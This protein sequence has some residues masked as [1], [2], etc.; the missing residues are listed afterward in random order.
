MFNTLKLIFSF[1]GL[2]KGIKAIP[3]PQGPTAT[4]VAAITLV[5][6]NWFAGN[7]D[8]FGKQ[9]APWAAIVVTALQGV[10][11]ISALFSDAAGTTGVQVSVTKAVI[12]QAI[13]TGTQALTQLTPLVPREYQEYVAGFIP[14]LQTAQ[15]MSWLNKEPQT[16]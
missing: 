7:G 13:A 1:N 8:L 10:H 15:T 11:S 12:L 14:V 16:T 4:Y 2:V 6:A 5:L 9:W 3:I